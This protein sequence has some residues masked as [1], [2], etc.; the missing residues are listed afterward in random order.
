[1]EGG[2][3]QIATEESKQIIR[4]SRETVPTLPFRPKGEIY[5]HLIFLTACRICQADGFH[6]VIT[7]SREITY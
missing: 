4:N 2:F 3:V 5:F 1:M 6:S 7:N